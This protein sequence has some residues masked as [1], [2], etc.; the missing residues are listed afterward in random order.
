MNNL[1]AISGP[2]GIGKTQLAIELA[3][4]YNTSIIS[5]DS[6]QIY[7]ELNIGVARPNT[8]ELNEVT[9]HLIGHRS[10]LHPYTVQ[11]FIHD[12]HHIIPDSPS[13]NTHRI[14][15]GGTGFFLRALEFGLDDLPDITSS[16]REK[17]RIEFEQYGLEY[18]QNELKQI[19]PLAYTKIDLNNPRRI[20]R[21]LEIYREHGLVYSKL[22]ANDK[23]KRARNDLNFHHIVLNTSRDVLYDRINKRVDKMIEEGLE[24]EAKRLIPHKN[25]NALQTVGYKEF[26][27]YFDSKISKD[28]AVD[29]I[30]QHTRNY[31]KRQITWN[32]KYLKDALWIDPICLKNKISEIKS[33]VHSR[34][35]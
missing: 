8:S 20:L 19:D 21:V 34:E 10:I 28:V 24:E 3:K 32:K 9:H 4:E 33:Y 27:D 31:A 11:N 13:G 25:L 22:I 14:L 5:F 7:S 12:A 29:K 15:V 6:R 16:T 2:T 23:P 30:K 18:I 17:L 26:F 35:I 1:I